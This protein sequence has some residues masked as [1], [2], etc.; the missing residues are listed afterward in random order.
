M[1]SKIIALEGLDDVGKS[2]LLEQ[3]VCHYKP[4]FE[5]ETWGDYYK[6]CD[7]RS[8]QFMKSGLTLAESFI[9]SYREQLNKMANNTLKIF[10]RYWY[11]TYAYQKDD[12]VLKYVYK[13]NLPKPDICIWIDKDVYSDK[14]CV[15]RIRLQ[16]IHSRYEELN[17]FCME[18]HRCNLGFKYIS[19]NNVINMI[20]RCLGV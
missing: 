8:N 6:D 18:M 3:L 5:I 12:N 16:S 7:K 1:N 11:S 9:L 19:L 10:D 2:Y 13:Y 15:E 4:K 20:K 17:K 14:E